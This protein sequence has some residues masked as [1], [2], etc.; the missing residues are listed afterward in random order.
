MVGERAE[1][2]LCPAL[3]VELLFRGLARALEILEK[4]G[5]REELGDDLCGVGS[6]R[7]E[8]DAPG[9]DLV[10]ETPDRPGCLARNLLRKLRMMALMEAC[11]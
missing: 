4:S 11:I 9:R 6:R 10:A 7:E 8:A 1:D 5:L 3:A 2:F